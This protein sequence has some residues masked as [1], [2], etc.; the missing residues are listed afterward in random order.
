MRERFQALNHRDAL[1]DIPPPIQATAS[2]QL[3][4]HHHTHTLVSMRQHIPR[5]SPLPNP[6]SA[7]HLVACHLFTVDSTP[8]RVIPRCL[9]A[10]LPSLA[11][12][13]L[14]LL[15]VVETLPQWAREAWPHHWPC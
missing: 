5:T 12:S 10:N 4:P 2:V 7:T 14:T 8:N 3:P 1:R 13:R 11:F 15:V 9:G 6:I